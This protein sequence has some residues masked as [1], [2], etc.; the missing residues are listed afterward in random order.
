MGGAQGA[1]CEALCGL[2]ASGEAARGEAVAI[3]VAA[4]G[5][6]AV[7]LEQ[8]APD[9]RGTMAG[10]ARTARGG[11]LDVDG[12]CR[13]ARAEA[14]RAVRDEGAEREARPTRRQGAEAGGGADSTL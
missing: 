11:N 12:R 1:K 3:S 9:A 8:A 2:S 5:S 7:R 13:A 6:M 4:A 10:E 14:M